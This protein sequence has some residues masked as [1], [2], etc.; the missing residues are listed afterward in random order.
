M[1]TS[2]FLTPF[3][4][5]TV[6]LED[7]GKICSALIPFLKKQDV[8][9]LYGTL[10]AVKTTFTQYLLQQMGVDKTT[11]TS[12][13]FTLV[14]IYTPEKNPPLWHFDLYRLT[15]PEEIYE[16]GL[17]EALSTAIS[18]IEWPEKLGPYL[19]QNHLAIYLDFN[20]TEPN[21][22]TLTFI[23]QNAWIERYNEL[24]NSLSSLNT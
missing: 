24:I 23:P 19:P 12:P 21:A 16:I 1:N 6:H 20:S 3:T 9:A 10:G 18:V 8:I 2:L 22:R 14:Q 17:E 13:T 4:I 5:N 7:L 11:V 15:H